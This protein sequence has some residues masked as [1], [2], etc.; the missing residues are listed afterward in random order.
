MKVLIASEVPQ[1]Y[2]DHSKPFEIYTE[3]SNYQLGSCIM[4]D[5]QPVAYY[6]KKFNPEQQRYITIEKELLSI[7]YTLPEFRSMLLGAKLTIYID[8]KNLTYKT[9]NN[10]RVLCWRLFLEE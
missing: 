7:V 2:L 10:L 3:A 5:G 8:Y 4:K 6:S 1:K 9:L